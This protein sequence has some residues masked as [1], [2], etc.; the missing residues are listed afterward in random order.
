MSPKKVAKSK[1]RQSSSRYDSLERWLDVHRI[2]MLLVLSAMILVSALVLT[3][4]ETFTLMGEANW[5]TSAD[6]T[7]TQIDDAKQQL[8][9]TA[10][11][12]ANITSFLGNVSYFTYQQNGSC[13]AL[14]AAGTLRTIAALINISIDD[15]NNPPAGPFQ[16]IF[17]YDGQQFGLVANA[18]Q[19]GSYFNIH[20]S[21]L[22]IPALVLASNVD[23]SMNAPLTNAWTLIALML[24][25]YPDIFQPSAPILVS[26]QPP[27]NITAYGV[28][29][30]Y[31]SEPGWYKF[32]V[33][34]PKQ[35]AAFWATLTISPSHT[36]QDQHMK[37][38][39]EV[40]NSDKNIERRTQQL[41]RNADDLLN[42]GKNAS[43]AR[44]R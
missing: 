15:I 42:E 33:S 6:V 12:C 19:N 26:G 5:A 43:D 2:L 39:T 22:I 4:H 32:F 31:S 17:L 28:V 9:L 8:A 7:Q 27:Y 37:A 34:L 44:S 29:P 41:I 11:T 3:R 21:F 35:V 38:T 14:V 23:G 16:S 25:L 1:V 18:N 10:E 30:A 24:G 20:I 36:I 13:T 40:Q